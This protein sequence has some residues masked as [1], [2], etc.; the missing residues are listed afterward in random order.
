MRARGDGRR[1]AIMT[2]DLEDYRRQELRDHLGL[3]Q[4]ANPRE[5]ERQLD[6]VLE[7]LDICDAR[8]TF[9]AVGRLAAEL[10]RSV[11]P[12]IAARHR[13]GCHGHEHE[14]VARQGPGR[15]RED[16][17]AAK[18]ELQ[19][20]AGVPVVSFRAPYMSS[21]GCDPWFGEALAS[22]G[23][24][25]DSSRRL[26]RPPPGFHGTLP[27]P[28]TGGEVT[29]VPFPCI[30][31][32]EKRLTIIGGTYFR[33]LPLPVITHLLA[34]CERRGFVPLVYLH[35]YDVD[36]DAPPLA[37]PRGYWR[38]RAG[39]RMRR[40]GRTSAASKLRALARR[41]AFQPMESLVN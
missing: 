3:P 8:A 1:P 20:A 19:D 34:R 36:P 31:F 9:L 39:D 12:R 40:T 2:I 4:P 17:R 30:G 25:L 26:R 18:A 15:F 22:V 5:V 35:P 32:G 6:I 27:V 23:F 11:W 10:S 33:L 41:Y 38:Q 13:I 14:R 28:G 16:L 37:Y 7:L 21:D 24:R 29:E